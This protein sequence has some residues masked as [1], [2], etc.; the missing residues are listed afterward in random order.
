MRRILM[1]TA[2]LVLTATAGT[3]HS[4]PAVL[5]ALNAFRAQKGAPPVQYSKPLEIAAQRHAQD[6]ARRGF[7]SHRGSNGS[8]VGQRVR[9]AGYGFCFVAENIAMGQRSLKAVMQAWTTSAGHRR[10]M[11]DRRA[12]EVALVKADNNIWVMV[13]GRPGC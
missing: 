1:T 2:L 5:G 11:L 9:A 3:A 4:E 6:M 8:N 12:A 7:F 13:L 10:N